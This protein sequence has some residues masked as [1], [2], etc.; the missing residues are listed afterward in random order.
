[1]TIS[2]A[3]YAKTFGA[4]LA[5]LVLT[6]GMAVI[7]LGPLTLAAAMAVAT[8][9]AVLIV[10]IFMHARVSGPLIWLAAGVGAI[11]LAILLALTLADFGTRGW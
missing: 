11:W 8:T 9:K 3:T 2:P 4:L 10:L 7:D 5:L 1:M 6:I